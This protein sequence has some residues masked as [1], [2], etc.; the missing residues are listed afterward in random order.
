MRTKGLRK[1]ST[2][3]PHSSSSQGIQHLK[4]KTL[5]VGI[6]S[7]GN[8]C[9]NHKSQGIEDLSLEACEKLVAYPRKKGKACTRQVFASMAVAE[10]TARSLAGQRIE[11]KAFKCPDCGLVHLAE[12]IIAQ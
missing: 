4:S 5:A 6:S 1:F 10:S 7:C 11:A 3:P 2:F 9:K 12:R 8:V